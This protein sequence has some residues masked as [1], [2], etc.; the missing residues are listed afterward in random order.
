MPE[1][2]L[3]MLLMVGLGIVLTGLPAAVVLIT[4]AVMGAAISLITGTVTL[5]ILTALPGRLV[6]L[7]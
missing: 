3:A 1:L 6:N 2:G 7:F 4:V 5:P